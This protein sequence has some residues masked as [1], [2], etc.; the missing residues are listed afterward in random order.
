M[1]V[2]R[3]RAYEPCCGM[4]QK[5]RVLQE[6]I[7]AQRGLTALELRDRTELPE[8]SLRTI[9]WELRKGDFLE[10]AGGVRGR[11]R[12]GITD[13]GR[14]LL[15]EADSRWSHGPRERSAQAALF[16]SIGLDEVRHERR[17]LRNFVRWLTLE[18]PHLF[19]VDRQ[20]LREKLDSTVIE[21][22]SQDYSELQSVLAAVLAGT[23]RESPEEG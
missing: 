7:H 11:Y 9:L 4:T 16:E 10:V 21:Y 13:R 1:P 22:L 2:A 20:L 3:K 14:E 18:H 8:G 17:T 5:Q 6:L 23:K 19:A 15:A 12:Y